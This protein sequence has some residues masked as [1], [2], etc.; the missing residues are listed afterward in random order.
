MPRT[1]I[2]GST[3]FVYQK[4]IQSA[5]EASGEKSRAATIRQRD[6]HE[7][8]SRHRPVAIGVCACVDKKEKAGVSF[9]AIIKRGE[10]GTSRRFMQRGA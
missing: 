6:D 3:A 5:A 2:H 4:E 8:I 7:T 10:A 9:G 1:Q